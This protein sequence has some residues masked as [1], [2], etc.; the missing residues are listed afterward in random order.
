MRCAALR[1]GA[2]PQTTGIGCSPEQAQKIIELR[3]YT[4]VEDLNTRLGQGKKKA[5]PAGISPRM[6]VDSATIFQ[7]YGRVDSILEDCEGIGAELKKEIAGWTLGNAAAN[8][9][10]KGKQRDTNETSRDSSVSTE[11]GALTLTHISAPAHKPKYYMTTQPSILKP[12]V[13]LKE[14]QMIGVNWLSL[15]Y[16][17]GLSCILADEMGEWSSRSALSRT[18]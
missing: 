14:Y 4:S 3:P 12:G 2:D 17:K 6:F 8:G 5:G 11:E 18:C 15:L 10:P 16:Q 13:T 9:K 1:Q 7:G